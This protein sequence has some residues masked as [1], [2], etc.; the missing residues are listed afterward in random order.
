MEF[1]ELGIIIYSNKHEQQT[2]NID[3]AYLHGELE[4]KDGA[5]YVKVPTNEDRFLLATIAVDHPG[6][7][8]TTFVHADGTT[9][10]VLVYIWYNKRIRGFVV[11]ETDTVAKKDAY[12]KFKNVEAFI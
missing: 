10:N 3:G 9:E 12:E 8:K 6:I 1:K 4:S 7:Y 11:S 2:Y 5:D